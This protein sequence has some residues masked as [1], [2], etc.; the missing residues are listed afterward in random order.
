MHR[1]TYRGSKTALLRALVLG[2]LLAGLPGSLQAQSA[3]SSATEPGTTTAWGRPWLGPWTRAADK[4]VIRPNPR[5]TF[6]DPISGEV[7]AWEALHTFN[8]AAVV[9]DGRV[10]VLYRAEDNSGAMAIGGHVSRLGLAVSEDG[11]HFQQMPTPVFCPENDAQRGR[12]VPG[13]VEDPRLVEA[14]DGS[15][16]LTYTQWSRERNSYSV[17]VA[18]STDLQHWTKHGP[19]FGGALGGRYDELKY[20][21][22]GIVTERRG[23]RL[24]AARI[25]GR[26]WMYWGEIEV[27]LAVSEDLVHWSPVETSPG[28]PLVLLRARPGKADSAFPET[29]PPPVRTAQGI[30]M[31]YN[32]KNAA[33]AGGDTRLQPGTYSVEEALFSA[34]QPGRLLERTAKPVFHPELPFERSGQYAAGTTFA[35]G[36]VLFHG[37]WWM[38]YGCADSF[39]G[40]ATA[41]LR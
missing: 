37:K 40:V 2:F 11:V 26:F 33:G 7:T 19:A 27:G 13:G 31:L 4:P 9:R 17:G 39:V 30:L 35:E 6:Q 25:N 15:Y 10:Y 12:E 20:K 21:S 22:A 16:V 18:T 24:V 34:D 14:P 29:G 23:D 38:Y 28:K 1:I 41:P 32:A 36:L 8:P 3:R 5:A